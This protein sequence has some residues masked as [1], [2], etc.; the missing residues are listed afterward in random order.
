MPQVVGKEAS[1]V[2]TACTEFYL[3]LFPRLPEARSV[4]LIFNESMPSL[5]HKVATRFN[6]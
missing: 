3:F 5:G 6:L 2:C 1:L 4:W